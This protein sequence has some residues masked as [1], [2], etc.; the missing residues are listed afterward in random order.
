M[1]VFVFLSLIILPNIR[2]HPPTYT[3]SVE[4]QTAVVAVPCGARQHLPPSPRPDSGMGMAHYTLPMTPPIFL[5]PHP[6]TVRC[7]LSDISSVL[8]LLTL[9]VG[10]GPLNH[11]SICT[12]EFHPRHRSHHLDPRSR[13]HSDTSCTHAQNL[14]FPLESLTCD[15]Y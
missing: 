14:V 12:E 2:Y 8:C 3:S 4:W 10:T 1:P 11:V 7:L 15:D 13:D 6:G 5:R 9:Y